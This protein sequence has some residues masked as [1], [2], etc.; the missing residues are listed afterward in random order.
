MAVPG[1][2][3]RGGGMLQARTMTGLPMTWILFG[4]SLLI[5]LLVVVAIGVAVAGLARAF[6]RPIHSGEG[7]APLHVRRDIAFAALGIAIALTGRLLRLNNP[8]LVQYIPLAMVGLGGVSALRAFLRAGGAADPQAPASNTQAAAAGGEIVSMA[9]GIGDLRFSAA[10]RT[11]RGGNLRLG[12]GDLDMDL[13][14]VSLP[15]GTHVLKAH[16]GMGDLR[17]RPPVDVPT[18]IEAAVGLGEVRLGTQSD[19]GI[20]NRLV[21][22]TPGYSD[23][24]SR[25]VIAAFVGV[26]EIRI[27]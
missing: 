23:A 15:A 18:R 22:E 13:S 7:P 19:S 27:P 2:R 26:G 11:I 21:R 25:L 16:V 12:I 3:S 1:N 5:L 20:A 17:I 10:G 14:G 24:V 6:S 8:F 4:T 9:K